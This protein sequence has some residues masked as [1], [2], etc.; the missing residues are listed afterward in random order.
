MGTG[1]QAAFTF[2]PASPI[3]GQPVQLIN[4]SAGVAPLSLWWE[5]GDGTSSTQEN[6]TRIYAEEGEY[7]VRLT[8]ANP[9]GTSSAAATIVVGSAGAGELSPAVSTYADFYLSDDT[10]AVGQPVHLSAPADLGPV[11]IGWN[12]GDGST[13]REHTP[14]HVYGQ[15][16]E[17]VVTLVLGEGEAAIQ[18]T[19]RVV[20]DYQPEA[21]IV[22]SALRV[23]VG[24][25]VTLTAMPWARERVDYYWDLGDGMEGRSHQVVTSYAMEGTYTVTLAVSNEHGVGL[26][27]VILRVGPPVIYLPFVTR[28]LPAEATVA[29]PDGEAA[30]GGP[31]AP[32]DP[33][34]RELLQAVN[35]QREAAGLSPLVWA[36]E[37]ARSSQHHV[38]DMATNG[39]TSHYGSEGS[40]PIDRMRQAS[41]TG[42]YAGECTAWGFSDLASVMAWWM[43]SPPHRTIILSTVATDMGG[44]YTYNPDALN[45][46][47]WTIDFGA[48]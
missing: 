26:D 35:V 21:D 37:L 44:A 11:S 41:Y 12:L 8:V 34:A 39:F 28:N 1:P 19:R 48:R 27:T 40:R 20:V 14:T 2:E 18:S 6:P 31:P 13:S 4:Q 25:L 7:T 23:G 5:F 32:E 15:P 22:S 36:T 46:H 38:E 47:Y 24:E 45:V 29:Q 16:G 10:P 30:E 33:L 17:Y 3:A 43:G 9:G 42:D